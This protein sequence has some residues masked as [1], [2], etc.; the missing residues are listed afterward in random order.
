LNHGLRLNGAS[1]S[2]EMT[3]GAGNLWT[4]CITGIV[5]SGTCRVLYTQ[6]TAAL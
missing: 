4:G 2:Y 5:A 6:G 1:C 3:M